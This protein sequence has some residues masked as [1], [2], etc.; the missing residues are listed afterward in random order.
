MKWLLALVAVFQ[1]VPK[2]KGSSPFPAKIE[3]RE[4]LVGK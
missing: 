3:L 1:K 2:V 4:N